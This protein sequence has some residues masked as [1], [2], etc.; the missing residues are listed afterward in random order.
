MKIPSVLTFLVIF[1]LGAPLFAQDDNESTSTQKVDAKEERIK[2]ETVVKEAEAIFNEK[3]KRFDEA[4]EELQEA[5]NEYFKNLSELTKPLLNEMIDLSE[6]FSKR[7]TPFVPYGSQYLLNTDALQQQ[8]AD[9]SEGVI[10][11]SFSE[12]ET[13]GGVLITS[14]IEGAPA[15]S[16][17]LQ[18]GDIIVQIDDIDVLDVDNPYESTTK[19]INDKGSGSSVQLEI[20]RD[21]EKMDVEVETIDRLTLNALM[22]QNEVFASAPPRLAVST[23]GANWTGEWPSSARY[24]V[25]ITQ[26]TDNNIFVMEIEEDFGEYFGVEYGVLVLKAKDVEGLQPGDILLEID[27]QPVRSLSHAIRYKRDA[28]DEVEILFKRNKRNKSI[29]LEKD[30]FSLNAILQ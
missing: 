7:L 18:S 20:R 9:W 23:A 2:K 28:D 19:I 5:R 16:A 1:M 27:D 22:A 11:V 3:Q 14:V 13:G 8:L 10:G 12:A 17:G 26:R 24:N 25:L 29:T 21:Y 15:A 4:A 6:K 30:Q